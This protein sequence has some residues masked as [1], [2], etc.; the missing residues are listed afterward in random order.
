[1]R[2][3]VVIKEFLAKNGL[4]KEL[5]RYLLGKLSADPVYRVLYRRQVSVFKEGLQ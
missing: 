5:R 4:E 1:M 3:P 2:E